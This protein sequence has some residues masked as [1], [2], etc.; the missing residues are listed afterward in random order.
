MPRARAARHRAFRRLWLCAIVAAMNLASGITASA[1]D[2]GTAA[3][4]ADT[5][6]AA[7]Q[8]HALFDEHWDTL[9]RESPSYASFVGDHRFDDRFDDISPAAVQRRRAQ[10]SDMMRRLRAIDAAMLAEPDRVSREVLLYELQA[11]QRIDRLYGTLALEDNPLPVTQM[12]G[13][14]HWLPMLAQLT[15]FA[16]V[17]DYDNYLK[18][19][20][21][22]PAYVEQLTAMLQTGIDSGWM[23]P[24]AAMQRV[25]QQFDALAAGDP[26]AHPLYAPF[27][28]VDAE[29]DGADKARLQ[30]AARAVITAEVAPTFARLRE[31]LRERYLPAATTTTAAAALPGGPAYYAARLQQQNTTTLS[32]QQIHDIGL[33]EVARIEAEMERVRARSGFAGDM[34]AFRAHLRSDPQFFAQSEAELLAAFRD[35]AKRVDPLLPGLFREL[36][37]LPYGIRA[38]TK[39][40]G[41]NAEHYVPGAADGS[42]AGWFEANAN[43]LRRTARWQMTTLLLHE[44]VPG[45]HLQIARAQ[46]VESLPAFRRNAFFVGYGEGWALYAEA[47]GERMGLYAD[48]LDHFGHLD[49]L[50]WRAVRLVVDPGLH[51]LGW[52][53]QRA[54]DYM[55]AHSAMGEDEITAELDRYL[56]MPGQATAYLI[57]RLR[58]E[59]LRDKARAALGE[60]FD[61]RAFH[62]AVLDTG[63]VPLDVLDA[64][65]GRW[66]EAQQAAA[67]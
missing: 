5:S 28:T 35:I 61:L 43:N 38:M 56:V 64:I 46:E 34:A 45:H 2:G 55:R 48:P 18:R 11:R 59:A 1:A 10:H 17:A 57:G 39:E 24:A 13:P 52:S 31:F 7:A 65:I 63:A 14:Q 40:Q 37:R 19:L 27:L 50:L 51:A 20:A 53:R 23:P 32:A 42:R 30:Q 15:R 60:R 8:L 29:I 3:A 36:P 47:L 9:L 49:A 54:F 21:A 4:A 16:S 58:I 67:K 33:R 41:D 22:L 12:D 62:N 66:I 44:T 6:S 25:P 26:A